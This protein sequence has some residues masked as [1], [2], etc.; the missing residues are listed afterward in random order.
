M[1]LIK[2]ASQ[3]IAPEDIN[4][5]LKNV[6]VIQMDLTEL[7]VELIEIE[8]EKVLNGDDTSNYQRVL[9]PLFNKFAHAA[10]QIQQTESLNELSREE[11]TKI[12][13]DLNCRKDK[14]LNNGV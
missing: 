1:P 2:K 7:I 12:Y 5:L 13:N 10:P 4:Y 11:L 3:F 6:S 14:V 8:R 9:I